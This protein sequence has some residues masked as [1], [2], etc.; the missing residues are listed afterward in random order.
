MTQKASLPQEEAQRRGRKD[1]R[2]E[3]S[4][5][6]VL[7]SVSGAQA[8][9]SE[10]GTEQAADTMELPTATAGKGCVP[11]QGLLLA[12]EKG[13]FPEGGQGDGRKETGWGLLGG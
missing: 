10:G 3:A 5:A 4:G 9:L 2:A 13:Q 11:W 12:G 1:S 8:L 6:A 7:V